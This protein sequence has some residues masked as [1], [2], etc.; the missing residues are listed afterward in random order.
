MLN[1]KGKALLRL[2]IMLLIQFVF[3]MLKI[4][5]AVNWNWVVVLIPIFLIV[6]WELLSMVV[7]LWILRK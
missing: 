4:T 5:G 7:F 1:Q 2:F 3:I 6:F